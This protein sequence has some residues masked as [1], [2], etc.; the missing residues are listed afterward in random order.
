MTIDTKEKVQKLTT[1]DRCDSCGAQAYVRVT[2]VS[3][4]LV[5]CGHHFTK[6]MNDSSASKAMNDF[7]FEIVDQRGEAI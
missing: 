5:F 6:I 2:G 3:G 7:A 1:A 4:E